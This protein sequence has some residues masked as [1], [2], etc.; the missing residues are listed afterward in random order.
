MLP[1]NPDLTQGY[2]TVS[3]SP[4]RD[5]R[6]RLKALASRGLCRICL[7]QSQNTRQFPGKFKAMTVR[8]VRVRDHPHL[9]NQPAQHLCG[10]PLE[11]WL[12]QRLREFTVLAPVEI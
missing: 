11:A 3:N 1:L 12:V 6:Y 2:E 9:R 7:P 8:R 5:Q 10:L 4:S